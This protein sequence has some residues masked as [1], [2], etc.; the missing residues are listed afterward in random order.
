M[1]REQLGRLE[2]V[3]IGPPA[4]E[5]ALAV[6]DA[7]LPVPLPPALRVFLTLCDGARAGDVEVFSA[8]RITETT[9]HGAHTWQ[10]PDDTLVIGAAGPG[11]ALIMIA[12]RDE[13]DEVDND[14]WDARTMEVAAN[15]PLDL[16]VRH[17]G[18]SLRD[19][20]LWSAL[21]ALAPALERTR[22]SLARDVDALVEV[23]IASRVGEPLPA[24]LSGFR[25]VSV[26]P[27]ARLL[28]S[29]EYERFLLNYRPDAP[30]S[31]SW[32]GRDWEQACESVVSAHLRDRIRT[33]PI[34]G[35]IG[36]LGPI[37]E[38]GEMTA[39]DIVRDHALFA[40]LGKARDDLAD[41]MVSRRDRG[42]RPGQRL[43]RVF[44]AGHVPVSLQAAI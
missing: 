7:L 31:G 26:A 17:Q 37:A 38:D 42:P 27:G 25:Q 11:R 8:E 24:S 28:V 36:V 6:A 14:P 10:L 35:P 40:L 22:V 32:A 4:D 3:V 2:G 41:M 9:N 30:A 12:G 20:D 16:F 18:V 1:T 44:L 29:E 33:S 13:V 5:A 43:A 23:G 15:T 39:A 21:P 34:S 19:R